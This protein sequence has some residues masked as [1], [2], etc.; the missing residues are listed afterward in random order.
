MSYP[1]HVCALQKVS[2]LDVE[3]AVLRLALQSV[4][5]VHLGAEVEI[6]RV[7]GRVDE[8]DAVGDLAGG[9][10]TDEL[11]LRAQKHVVNLCA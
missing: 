5:T 10:R 9:A 7:R 4:A 3:S 8:Q 1:V 6:R 2:E 11:V